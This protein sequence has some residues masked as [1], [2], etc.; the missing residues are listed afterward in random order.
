MSELENL[1]ASRGHDL[2]AGILPSAP[3]DSHLHDEAD[4][5]SGYV[6]SH[7]T[8][9]RCDGPGLRFV[10]FVSGCPLRCSY[11][12]NPD[13]WHL[14]DGT[15]IPAGRVIR[16]P[17]AFA[18]ALSALDGGVTISGGEPLVQLAFTRRIF[19]AAKKMD[20]HTAIE[21]SGY[22]GDRMDDSYLANLDLISRVQTRS[23]IVT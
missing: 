11:C 21:T 6:H 23:P 4:G 18:P 2:R 7:E 5:T 14:K 9:S 1:E 16:R 15:F 3:D 8:A 17:A 12:H 10:L 13:S 20:L 22:L 19:A